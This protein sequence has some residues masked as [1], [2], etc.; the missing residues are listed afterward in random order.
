MNTKEK[1][2]ITIQALKAGFVFVFPMMLV[3]A[4][5]VIV[6]IVIMLLVSMKETD[7]TFTATDQAV[8]MCLATERYT[9]EEC[10]QLI[11]EQDK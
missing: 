7:N 10:I 11:G 9:R 6:A 3:I 4:A 2:L 8:M 1:I 5:V